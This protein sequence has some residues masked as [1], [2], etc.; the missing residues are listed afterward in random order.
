MSKQ[1]DLANWYMRLNGFLTIP[2]FILHPPHKGPQRAEVDVIGVRFPFRREFQGSDVDDS[3]LCYSETKP[4]LFIAEV[5]S[6]EINANESWT[7]PTKA[8]IN[9]VLTDLGIFNNVDTVDAVSEGLYKSGQF[10]GEPY[11]CSLV[12]VGNIDSNL[13]PPR[14]SSVPRILWKDLIN[15]I[16]ARMRKFTN[17][18]A[19]NQ[20]WDQLGQQLYNFATNNGNVTEFEER[21]RRHCGLPVA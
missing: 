16:Y 21:V 5:K 8:N 14:Y 6:R 12:F 15:F 4:S 11:Y 9:K 3:R 10:D 1:E 20:Q 19:N 13:I 17:I 18:K 2:N 7:D